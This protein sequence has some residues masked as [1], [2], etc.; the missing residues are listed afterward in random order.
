MLQLEYGTAGP[1]VVAEN[2]VAARRH[3]R[4]EPWVLH[5][6][7]IITATVELPRA[8]TNPILPLN[9]G[10]PRPGLGRLIG[11]TCAASPVGP[12]ELAMLAVPSRT[13]AMMQDW[14]VDAVGS[15]ALGG[16]DALG[17]PVRPGEV[18]LDPAA[19]STVEV[20]DEHSVLASLVLS[21]RPMRPDLILTDPWVF[22]VVEPG[23]GSPELWAVSVLREDRAAHVDHHF[24]VEVPDDADAQWRAL[25]G[26]PWRVA[27]AVVEC[28]RMTLEVPAHFAI[29]RDD[30]WPFT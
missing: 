14:I 23:N 21:P 17:F 7:V 3:G 2:R 13:R 9:L 1:E 4:T 19:S 28:E 24:R 15:S 8:R 27:A 25:L 22:P 30:G 20:A 26:S 10:Q 18:R 12:F 6:A 16:G 11:L 29:D 5:D